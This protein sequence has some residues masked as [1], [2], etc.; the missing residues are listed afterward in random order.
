MMHK[1][2][3]VYIYIYMYVYTHI[4]IYI[5]IYIY[6]YTYIYIYTYCMYYVICIHT[7][8]L[9]HIYDVMSVPLPLP[10]GRR[11]SLRRSA[12]PRPGCPQSGGLRRPRTHRGKLLHI[13]FMLV[14]SLL[15][16]ALVKFCLHLL[17][18]A[19][20]CL[21]VLLVWFVVYCLFT[22]TAV[23]LPHDQDVLFETP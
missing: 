19:L 8:I 17:W 18:Q 20:A 16:F 1:G 9:I 2:V 11:G 4:Y 21:F 7:R 5:Y 13:C 15:L 14:A 6:V 3:C 22:L 12:G 10:Q 23:S